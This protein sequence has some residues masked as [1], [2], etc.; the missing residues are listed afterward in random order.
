MAATSTAK[1]VQYGPVVAVVNSNSEPNK[2]YEV[3]QNPA[4][5]LSCQCMGWRFNKDTPRHC[6]HTDAVQG[7]GKIKPMAAAAVAAAHAKGAPTI[8]E[9]A[10]RVAKE[11]L[12][13]GSMSLTT[14][15]DK[16][17][18]AIRK[19]MGALAAPAAATEFQ[20]VTSGVRMITLD[21]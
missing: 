15:T 6:K 2:K 4:G 7:K 12:Q 17:E 8:R 9:E 10:T 3:R 16:I 20:E 21:D 5:F 19:F 18:A 14:A 13:H 1:D 11:I